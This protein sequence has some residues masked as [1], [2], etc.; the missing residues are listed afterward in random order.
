MRK[1]WGNDMTGQECLEAFEKMYQNV[2][3]RYAD[4]CQKM[5]TLKAEGK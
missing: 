5:D 1:T 4:T 3:D 2:K